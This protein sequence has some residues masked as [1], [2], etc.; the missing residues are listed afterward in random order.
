MLFWWRT[1]FTDSLDKIESYKLE[2]SLEDRAS[3]LDKRRE[4][5][6]KL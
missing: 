4:H 1:T 5:L 6:E 3:A 2:K